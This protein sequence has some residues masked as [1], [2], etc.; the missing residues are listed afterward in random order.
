MG[1]LLAGVLL[2]PTLN[3]FDLQNRMAQLARKVMSDNKDVHWKWVVRFEGYGR[4][5]ESCPTFMLGHRRR[6]NVRESCR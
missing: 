6:N 5:R 3:L 2:I 1:S 4:K